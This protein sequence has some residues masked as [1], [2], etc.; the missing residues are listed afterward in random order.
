VQCFN[1]AAITSLLA[2]TISTSR[3]TSDCQW[4]WSEVRS[5]IRDHL[6]LS[7]IHMQQCIISHPTSE[8]NA[9]VWRRGREARA[10]NAPNVSNV[11]PPPV[12]LQR[13]C[14]DHDISAILRTQ[15]ED[16]SS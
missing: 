11:T 15:A 4:D 14:A 16:C 7:L 8:D 2:T 13:D 10:S 3:D 1:T 12:Y 9:V 5:L 6:L